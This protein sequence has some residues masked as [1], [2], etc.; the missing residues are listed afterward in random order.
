MT[1]DGALIELIGRVA[2]SPDA[3]ALF[4]TKELA[5]WPNE[6][7]TALK[8]QNVLSKARPAFSAVCP[9]C[10]R[11]CVMPVHA[12]PHPTSPMAFIVCDKRSDINRVAVPVSRLEQWKAS[13]ASIADLLASLLDLHRSGVGGDTIGRWGIGTFKGVNHSSHLVLMVDDKLTLTLAGHSIALNDVLTLEGSDFKV[14]R[15]TLTRLVDEPIA[16]AGDAESATHRRARLTQRVHAV[17]DKGIK[18]FLKTVAAE[19]GISIT[20]LKQ[21]LERGNRDD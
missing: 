6:A 4:N 20:R 17:Q 8:T 10:E 14:D 9:G 15:R 11:E 21:I 18:A 3:R 7:V 16:G 5:Q 13:G 2:A 1:P 19:E 12:P